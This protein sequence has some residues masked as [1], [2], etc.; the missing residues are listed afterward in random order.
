[1]CPPGPTGARMA[2]R[3]VEIGGI[4]SK[5]AR[6]LAFGRLAVQRDPTLWEEPL[7]FDPTGSV[8]RMRLVATA[9]STSRSAP[10]RGRALKITSQC[11]RQPSAWPR[12]FGAPK[13]VR[14]TMS[15]RWR[16]RS[17]WWPTVQSGHAF[18]GAADHRGVRAIRYGR[19]P[20]CPPGRRRMCA[21]RFV[22]TSVHRCRIGHVLLKLFRCFRQSVQGISHIIRLGSL[23]GA[24]S[25]L[26][27]LVI[28]W[29][30]TADNRRYAGFD[31]VLVVAV[32]DRPARIV[33][34]EVISIVCIVQMSTVTD[35]GRYGWTVARRDR[36]SQR[37]GILCL[38]ELGRFDNEV[39]IGRG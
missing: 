11:W 29:Q 6:M 18:V 17:P 38:G 5:P 36:S 31:A 20:R 1:M 27:S 9:G 14:W 2:T 8:R 37:L 25:G 34:V 39:D 28:Q 26:I 4:R 35:G 24:S 23:L 33:G 7:T 22:P 30:A 19:I 21:S 3:D 16:C 13:F 10:A 15:S 32:Y 12:S